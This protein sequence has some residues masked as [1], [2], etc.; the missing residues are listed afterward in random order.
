[1]FKKILNWRTKPVDELKDEELTKR[2]YKT[3]SDIKQL[4][5]EVRELRQEFTGSE[6]NPNGGFFNEFNQFKNKTEADIKLMK[7][8]ITDMKTFQSN[9]KTGYN[10][11]KYILGGGIGFAL[12]GKFFN[13]F[14]K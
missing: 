12:I 9:Q 14:T 5:D 6:L 1:M 11:I 7:S 10:L 3:V 13:D 2:A 8:D 4:I